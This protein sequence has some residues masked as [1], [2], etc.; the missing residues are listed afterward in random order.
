MKVALVTG[1]A[2]EKGIGNAIARRL[3]ADGFAVAISDLDL[4]GARN[5]TA[6][7][8]DAPS[9]GL[10]RL[11]E[12][13][14]A[15][16]GTAHLVCGDVSS[17][18]DADRMVRETLARFG[19]LDVLV[20]NAAAPKRDE[21]GDI[22][23]IDPAEWDR[24]MAINA[25]GPFLMSRAV[26]P[27]MKEA[28][29]GRIVMISSLAGRVGLRGQAIYG[30]SKHAVIGLARALALDLAGWGI[31]ANAVCPGPIS[32]DRLIDGARR[33]DDDVEAELRQRA[34]AIPVGRLGRGADIA[35]AVAFLASDDSSFVTGQVLG[36]DGGVHPAA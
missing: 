4:G 35:A 14:A 36:V 19:R 2:R 34:A 11:A 13:I 1:C 17:A 15:G 24:V 21:L 18:D 32:T 31:T 28:R 3:A 22:E 8:E 9:Q 30:A 25:R 23:T 29:A 26:I 16:G 6:L 27:T 5:A 20:N 10:A 33:V 12:D 7:P